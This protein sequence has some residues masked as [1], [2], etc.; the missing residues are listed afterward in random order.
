MTTISR[1]RL[2][3]LAGAGL[4]GYTASGWLP[5]LADDIAQSPDRKRHCILLWMSGGPSQTDTFDMKP[6]HA[7]GGEF[8]EIAYQRP[9]GCSHQRA[10][11]EA[12][13]RQAD[14]LAIVRGLSTKEGDHGRGT[15]PDADG[16]SADGARFRFP[17]IG[18]SLVEGVRR[19]VRSRVELRERFALSRV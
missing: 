10:S 16:A 17:T 14:K 11:A 5:A 8:K 12:G 7:N 1:R 13:C 18:A 4:C 19:N 9:Q 3:Q 2:F 6:G 15:L